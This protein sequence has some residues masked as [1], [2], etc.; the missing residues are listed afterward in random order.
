[1]ASI[2]YD[3]EFTYGKTSLSWRVRGRFMVFYYG[4]LR[5]IQL[6]NSIVWQEQ[7]RHVWGGEERV[8][9]EGLHLLWNGLQAAAQWGEINTSYL[10]C[11]CHYLLARRVYIQATS[12][13][14][15]KGPVAEMSILQFY[16]SECKQSASGPEDNDKVYYSLQRNSLLFRGPQSCYSGWDQKERSRRS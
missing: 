13:A 11:D 1:M 12:R 8:V 10:Q 7:R 15:T 5:L 6:G 16:S 3:L 14:V 4:S 2:G 9:L